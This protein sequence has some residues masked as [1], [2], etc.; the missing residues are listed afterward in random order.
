MDVP[1]LPHPVWHQSSDRGQGYSMSVVV[2]ERSRMRER[3]PSDVS[4]VTDDGAN[5]SETRYPCPLCRV[6]PGLFSG[7]GRCP[8]RRDL[9]RGGRHRQRR[10][11]ACGHNIHR[12]H[13]HDL[14]PHMRCLS[15]LRRASAAPLPPAFLNTDIRIWPLSA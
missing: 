15:L 13:R 1:D 6:S 12:S 8:L 11:N 2:S 7:P 9:R 4:G 3:G 14:F 5:L 10:M